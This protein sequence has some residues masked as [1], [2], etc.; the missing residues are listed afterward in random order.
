M[1]RRSASPTVRS[2]ACPAGYGEAVLPA[3]VSGRV[4]QGTVFAT[5]ND[6]Q[7][8]V[9]RLTGPHRDPHT[10]TPDYK[11]TAVRVEPVRASSPTPT[12]SP[13]A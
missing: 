10:N 8:C 1:H 5:F 4:P 3:E 9:N 11:V 12:A 2:S 13:T 7:V 6:P